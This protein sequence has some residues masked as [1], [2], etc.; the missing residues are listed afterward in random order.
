[1][2]EAI[3]VTGQTNT[4]R[5]LADGR[6]RMTLDI[7]SDYR[8]AVAQHFGETGTGVALALLN[9]A[10]DKEQRLE[11]NGAKYRDYGE[12]ARELKLSGFFRMPD[13]W[14]A[15]GTDKEFLLWLRNKPCAA[16]VPEP[17]NVCEGDIVAAHVRRIADGA[18]I[19]IKPQHAAIPLCNKHHML[20]HQKGEGALGGKEWFDEQRIKH[21]EKWAWECLKTQ[22]GYDSF[23]HVP[24][25][26]LLAWAQSKGVEK[27]LPAC[28]K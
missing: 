21:V 3:A 2:T 24:P 7:D 20:Q 8:V 10:V 12:Q 5:T 1:M 22:L 28:Y 4:Y 27:Y 23:K 14:R 18:G 17:N 15:I 13:V 9:T 11:A 16:G 25:V 19:G 26:E 6:I